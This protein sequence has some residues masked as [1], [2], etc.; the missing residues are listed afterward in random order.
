MLGSFI[1]SYGLIDTY[2]SHFFSLR[3]FT[4]IHSSQ[5]R[6]AIFRML[7]DADSDWIF[8][9]Y[10][11]TPTSPKWSDD[12]GVL[13]LVLHAVHFSVLAIKKING[14][15]QY[16]H[17]CNEGRPLPIHYQESLNMMTAEEITPRHGIRNTNGNLCGYYVLEFVRILIEF[18]TDIPNLNKYVISNNFRQTRGRMNDGVIEELDNLLN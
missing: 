16:I 18:G 15:F 8:C 12:N 14:S 3:F 2:M 6:D 10:F 7:K 4:M 13:V 17:L 9:E 11:P 1:I 5:V